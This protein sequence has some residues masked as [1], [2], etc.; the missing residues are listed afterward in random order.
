MIKILY[1]LVIF[2]AIT[3]NAMAQFVDDSKFGASS[4][5]I[6]D[7]YK[8]PQYQK[9]INTN[10]LAIKDSLPEMTA[11]RAITQIQKLINDGYNTVTK[12]TGLQGYIDEINQ[13]KNDSEKIKELY[14][15]ATSNA[16]PPKELRVDTTEKL[17]EHKKQSSLKLQKAM[18]L[19]EAELEQVVEYINNN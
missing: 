19:N 2:T 4:F 15:Y 6:I 9:M 12:P 18:G 10:Y 14:F 3:T 17:E 16:I 11:S 7:M 13:N 8:S 1:T 5:S